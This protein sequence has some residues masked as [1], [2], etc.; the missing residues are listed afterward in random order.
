M[1]EESKLRVFENRVCRKIFGP[2]R[3]GVTGEWRRIHNDE[4]NDLN[5]SPNIIRVVKSRS[6]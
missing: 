6:V 2:K 1:R 3:E 5:S 4:I